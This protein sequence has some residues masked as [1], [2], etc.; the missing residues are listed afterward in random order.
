MIIY[1]VEEAFTH[2]YRLIIFLW[3]FLVQTIKQTHT[4]IGRKRRGCFL[5]S[6]WDGSPVYSLFQ[7]SLRTLSAGSSHTLLLPKTSTL[8]CWTQI[9]QLLQFHSI[10][11]LQNKAAFLVVSVSFFILLSFCLCIIHRLLSFFFPSLFRFV[12]SL[13]N[14]LLE[15]I[16]MISTQVIHHR[17]TALHTH[18]TFA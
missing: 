1:T 14:Q 9:A 13:L 8:P 16:C 2:I 10:E 6:H 12:S 11:S 15:L 18:N 4:H 3:Y 5:G 7:P 17:T